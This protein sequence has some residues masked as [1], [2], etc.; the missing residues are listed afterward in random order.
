MQTY[1][2]NLSSR[3]QFFALLITGMGAISL[4]PILAEAAVSMQV[5]PAPMT[6]PI[7]AES[8]VAQQATSTPAGS[9]VAGA[10]GTKVKEL[11]QRLKQKGFDPG[12]IDGTFGPGTK[13][14]VIAFQKAKGLQAD[15]VA[16]PKTLA[17]LGI[18]PLEPRQSTSTASSPSLSSQSP[19]TSSS[20]QTPVTQSPAA[21]IVVPAPVIVAD[22]F[23]WSGPQGNLGLSLVGKF[24]DPEKMIETFE[25]SKVLSVFSGKQWTLRDI[26][27]SVDF[28]ANGTT[29]S[30][31]V[32]GP[33][34][35]LEQYLA[36]LKADYQNKSLLYDFGFS[37]VNFKPTAAVE[38]GEQSSR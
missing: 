23:Y 28:N 20:R 26:L 32:S 11:Q 21:N 9:L 14:A 10:T 1:L 22:R 6:D 3:S 25:L 8:W 16:G 17:A 30:W 5:F 13:T 7:E 2:S 18:K 27:V 37:E 35:V 19:K 29:A 12:S 24:I 36:V 31:K 4:N 34:P 38:S 15:G 33:R